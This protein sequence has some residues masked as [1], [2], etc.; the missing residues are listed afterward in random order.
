MRPAFLLF[1]LVL[2]LPGGAKAE[3]LDPRM[4]NHVAIEVN[5]LA[6]AARTA[7]GQLEIGITGP[8]SVVGSLGWMNLGS[9]QFFDTD[10]GHRY[11]RGRP[12]LDG[13]LCEVGPKVSFPLTGA[14]PTGRR[15]LF[16]GWA[17]VSFT[18]DW[19][20][21]E[22]LISS[23]G[24]PAGPGRRIRRA[25]VAV[26][27]GLTLPIGAGFYVGMGIG[28]G[29]RGGGPTIRSSG[30]ILAFPSFQRETVTPRVLGVVG[31]AL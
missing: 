10:A 29:V 3:P 19:L 26:D 2:L 4:A 20:R 18:Y 7:S 21:E 24:G 11:W 12:A 14:R 28:L 6:L 27:T 15:P 17:S 31:F 9:G 22:G 5:P 1:L 23:E 16:Y 25:G 13:L 8:L 30:A